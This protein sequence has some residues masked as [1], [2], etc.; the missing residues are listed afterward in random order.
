MTRTPPDLAYR[1]RV[2]R[3]AAQAD[4]PRGRARAWN[5]AFAAGLAVAALVAHAAGVAWST[6]GLIAGG[7]A[8]VIVAV[9]AR[10][11]RVAPARTRQERARIAGLVAVDRPGIRAELV[12]EHAAYGCQWEYRGGG[13][14]VCAF[15][16]S[17]A[18]VPAET[19]QE[20]A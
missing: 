15:G 12:A 7:V 20:V 14:R 1:N 8:A 11:L 5:L 2:F 13:V 18:L 17:E 16:H 19:L 6:V 10:T 9:I 4:M 3:I